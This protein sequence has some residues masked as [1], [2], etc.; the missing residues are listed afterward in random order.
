[1]MLDYLNSRRE[2]MLSRLGELVRRESPSHDKAA[3]DALSHGIAGRLAALGAV[4]RRV[5]NAEGGDHVRARWAA[6]G[7]ADLEAPAL[8]LGHFDTVWPRGTLDARPFRVEGGR[9]YG[10]GVYD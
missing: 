1:M 6:E 7:A 5:D 4:V 2:A 9:A 3:L 8:V 10:P